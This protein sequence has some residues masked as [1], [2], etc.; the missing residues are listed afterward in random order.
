MG[1][2]AA[3]DR[4]VC[5]ALSAIAASR[6]DPLHDA[7]HPAGP[8]GPSRLDAH[9]DALDQWQRV[10][11][12]VTVTSAVTS[13]APAPAPP[14][15]PLEEDAFEA[16][17]ALGLFLYR[18]P[19]LMARALRVLRHHVA[20]YCCHGAGRA[21]A[22]VA[23]SVGGAS[24]VEGDDSKASESG[25]GVVGIGR[26]YRLLARTV[27][28]ALA[29]APANFA[30]SNAVWG[31]LR[32][33]PF[34]ARF[35]VYRQ[36][37]DVWAKTPLLQGAA[38]LSVDGFRRI[39]RRLHNPTSQKEKREVLGPYRLAVAKLSAATPIQVRPP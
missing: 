11:D 13:S 19:R 27:L 4:G 30:A 28:P 33:L 32:L 1:V 21:A 3:A 12:D 34:A 15:G 10:Q 2:P 18:D 24:A 5:A 16:L 14:A 38:A 31:V 23:G 8:L 9:L 20:S 7:L 17:E 36:A 6:I 29:L 22:G 25:A 35:A 37:Q 39:C 26:V